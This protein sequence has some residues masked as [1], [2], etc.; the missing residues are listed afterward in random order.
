MKEIKRKKKKEEIKKENN[1]NLFEGIFSSSSNQTNSVKPQEKKPEIKNNIDFDLFSFGGENKQENKT[2]NKTENK[3]VMDLNSVF[4]M[5]N[6]TE[7]GDNGITKENGQSK[8]NEINQEG[9][10]Q[11]ETGS[12]GQDIFAFF[13]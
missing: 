9:T 8:V 4:G 11:N 13:Q 5:N 6:N 2:E 3:N 7:I 12:K 10:T 1:N